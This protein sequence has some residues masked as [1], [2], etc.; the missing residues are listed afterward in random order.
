MDKNLNKSVIGIIILVWALLSA[1]SEQKPTINIAVASNFELTLKK[2]LAQYP[3]KDY[4]I[5]IIAGSSGILANQI[6]NN[7]PYDLF[8]SADN[9]KPQLI[10]QQLKLQHK[11]QIYAVGKLVLWIPAA[12]GNN[13][14]QILPTLATL[15]IA[16]PKTAPYGKLAQDILNINEIPIKKLIQTANASQA[17]LYTKDAFTQGGFVPYSLMSNKN[18]GCIQ[19]FNSQALEQAMILLDNK[20]TELYK[21]MT[22]Q[23]VKSILK[24]NGYQ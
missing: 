12:A 18:E 13:C 7:A 24:Q 6:L 2:I 20:A 17:Y 15:A 22:S 8:L 21:F 23:Q 11:P 9:D 10:Y 16:N 3:N 14:L 5:N 4:E 19:I 1:C